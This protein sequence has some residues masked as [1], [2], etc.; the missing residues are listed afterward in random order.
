MSTDPRSLH[1]RVGFAPGA[2]GTSRTGR[3]RRCGH[4]SWRGWWDGTLVQGSRV[5]VEEGQSTHRGNLFVWAERVEDDDDIVCWSWSHRTLGVWLRQGDGSSLS[6]G[7]ASRRHPRRPVRAG[8]RK[9][10][11]NP[12]TEPPMGCREEEETETGS[13][14]GRRESIPGNTSEAGDGSTRSCLGWGWGGVIGSEL[15]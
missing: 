14:S 12:R 13:T 15:G 4:R 6:F 10:P 9:G 11:K 5:V 8:E 3:H 7:P 1:Q 2:R